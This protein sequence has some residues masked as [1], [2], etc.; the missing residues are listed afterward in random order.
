M[1]TSRPTKP[2]H[3]AA[4]AA[5]EWKRR[6]PAGATHEGSRAKLGA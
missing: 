5:G 3:R 6:W 2:L 4:G 1:R